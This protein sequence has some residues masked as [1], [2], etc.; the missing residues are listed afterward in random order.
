MKRWYSYILYTLIVVACFLY[1]LFPSDTAEDL[2][3]SY[4]KTSQPD[5]VWQVDRIKPSFPP[6]LRFMEMGIS[7]KK[8]AP[9]RVDLLVVRP[10]YW[11]MFAD[12]K[13]FDFRGS[14]YQ[15]D[16]EG[17]VEYMA[18][19]QPHLV[20]AAVD[21]RDIRLDDAAALQGLLGRKVLGRLNGE[22][23]Y[24]NIRGKEGIADIR[25]K[26]SNVAMELALPL[27][28]IGIDQLTFR[29]VDAMI[30]IDQQSLTLKQ[31][32]AVGEQADGE[33][34]G[35][36]RFRRPLAKSLLDFKGTVKP[37]TGL[38]AT[39]KN[40][41]PGALFPQQKAGDGGIPIKLY[42]TIEKPKISLR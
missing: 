5:V 27:L 16:I 8:S 19:A 25:L 7:Y 28:N 24:E 40:L 1:Y 39:I 34:S 3:A 35:T 14:V 38:L 9:T 4:L 30:T 10:D 6:G 29:S 13:A 33:L 42:G 12:K 18:G 17:R 32:S 26:L 36:I 21:F 2:I 23:R 11:M 37:H 20:R 41:V 22:A 31:C 15:G